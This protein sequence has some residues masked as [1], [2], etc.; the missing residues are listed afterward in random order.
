[1]QSLTRVAS[2]RSRGSRETDGRGQVVR[3]ADLDH[4]GRLADEAVGVGRGGRDRD[5]AGVRRNKRGA[6]LSV[7]RDGLAA[8]GH[9][10]RG[11]VG[12]A[13]GDD[14]DQHVLAGNGREAGRQL[15]RDL[16]RLE[17]QAP[18]GSVNRRL[19]IASPSETENATT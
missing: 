9:R 11:D 5:P 12:Q 16:R 15:D 14:V 3:V 10:Q 4:G 1:M 13:A 8:D 2:R 18:L 19:V 7:E 17:D 6:A